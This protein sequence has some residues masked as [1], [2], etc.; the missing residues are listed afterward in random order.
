MLSRNSEVSAGGVE[1]DFSGWKVGLSI[2]MDLGRVADDGEE[3]L[4]FHRLHLQAAVV[5]R[6]KY[7]K[8][9]EEQ[10]VTSEGDGGDAWRR[11]SARPAPILVCD[12]SPRRQ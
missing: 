3:R 5:K 10:D 8:P 9:W 6:G 2:A 4:W 12:P 7:G 11:G 1:V